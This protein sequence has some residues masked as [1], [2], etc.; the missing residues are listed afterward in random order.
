M[1][2]LP[3][4]ISLPICLA[5]FLAPAGQSHAQQ[6]A[7]PQ[8]QYNHHAPAITRET[9]A[10]IERIVD[11]RMA[12][13]ESVI[14][15]L[16]ERVEHLERITYMGVDP[17]QT[18]GTGSSSQ[19]VHTVVAGD[20][21]YG[22][23]RHYGV[24]VNDIVAVNQLSPNQPI[25][26]NDRLIIPHP[27]QAG[28][29]GGGQQPPV[30]DNNPYSTGG[31]QQHAGNQGGQGAQGGTYIVRPG[32]TLTRIARETGTSVNQ[33][34]QINGIRNPNQ[35]QVGQR[36]ALSGNAQPA[37]SNQGGTAG[38]TEGAEETY[39]YYEVVHGDTLEK[40]AKTFFTTVEEIRYLNQF[41]PDAQLKTGDKVMVPTSK[42]FQ[43]LNQQGVFPYS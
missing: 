8:G 34:M 24:S 35:L 15:G 17:G 37:P 36:L 29:T 14:A 23:S 27:G 7:Q 32:D 16:R 2:R 20:T 1:N 30:Q 9:E 11:Q 39:H 13:Q 21:L 4:Y 5:G 26:V 18:G 25:Y 43:H 33:L 19:V 38:A 42:Y 22:I 3:A 10:A 31:G 40:I 6:G 41:G 12:Q 28:Q